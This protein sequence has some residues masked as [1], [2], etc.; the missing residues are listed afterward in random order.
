MLSIVLSF[1]AN[2]LLA[3]WLL[4]LAYGHDQGRRL[5]WRRHDTSNVAAMPLAGRDYFR[6]GILAIS[7]CVLFLLAGGYSLATKP[8]NLDIEF[9][10]G[11]ALDIQ[12]PQAIT[13]DAA[14]QRITDSGIA[15][16][17]VAIGGTGHNMAFDTINPFAAAI[18]AYDAVII[19][20]ATVLSQWGHALV[21]L[22]CLALFVLFARNAFQHLLRSGGGL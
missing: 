8:L 9:K 2:V 15:P 22:V 3:H 4:H 18:N 16:A 20:S 1:L 12:L 11:T 13:Q 19:D 10:A 14:T 6:Y 5:F 7:G 21:I 17:T